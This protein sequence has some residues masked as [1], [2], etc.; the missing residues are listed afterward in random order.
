MVPTIRWWAASA[1]LAGAATALSLA[2]LV[3]AGVSPTHTAVPPDASAA[4]ACAPAEGWTQLAPPVGMVPIP[5]FNLDLPGTSVVMADPTE[6]GVLWGAGRGGIYRSTDCGLSWQKVGVPFTSAFEPDGAP[7]GVFGVGVDG[8]LYAAGSDGLVASGDGGQTWDAGKT[9]LDSP[10]HLVVGGTWASSLSVSPRVAGLGY[11]SL[12]SAPFSP[13]GQP[14][15]ARSTDAGK[16][17]ELRL[18]RT[19]V[20][21]VDP[22]SSDVVYL[23]SDD[24]CSGDAPC[25]PRRRLDRSVDGGKTF[26]PFAAFEEQLVAISPNGDSTQFWVVT[27]GGH[28]L[29]S[30]AGGTSWERI[31][32][33]DGGGSVFQ[34]SADPFD[35]HVVY[36]LTTSGQLWTYREAGS[37]GFPRTGDGSVDGGAG[38]AERGPSD[39]G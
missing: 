29:R 34:I 23:A 30:A 10:V 1:A 9:V 14:G 35:P 27:R 3:Q 21:A 38:D 13:G 4:A 22:L 18:R 12:R 15:L 36:V 17:W 33:P 24:G 28:L 26:E 6:P 25:L 37:P 31:D 8:T 32:L 2:A 11:A 20:V 16:N 39:D 7:V 5:R 19:G